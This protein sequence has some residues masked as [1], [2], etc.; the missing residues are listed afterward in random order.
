MFQGTLRRDDGAS[1]LRRLTKKTRTSKG[2]TLVETLIASTLFLAVMATIAFTFRDILMKSPHR[3]LFEAS[4]KNVDVALEGLIQSLTRSN[5][6]GVSQCDLGSNGAL[7][8]TQRES[9]IDSLGSPI[10]EE[11]LHLYWK[12]DE[13][14]KLL[15]AQVTKEEAQNEGF[16]LTK[17]FPQRPTQQQ[18]EAFATLKR[19]GAKVLAPDVSRFELS[20]DWL[21]EKKHL[22]ITIEIQ[23]SRMVE[24]HYINRRSFWLHRPS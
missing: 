13:G 1:L 19:D 16:Q 21:L 22:E 2:L 20:K 12:E 17:N 4:T 7:L 3:I 24:Q 9:G 5:F 11:S 18:L 10:W 6:H 8:A 23:N 15:Y 14:S